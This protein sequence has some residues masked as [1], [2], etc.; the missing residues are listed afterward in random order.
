MAYSHQARQP[1]MLRSTRHSHAGSMAMPRRRGVSSGT[2]LV[3]LGI[4]GGIIPFIGPMF[5]YHMDT[6]A[7]WTFTWDRLWLSILPGAAA[8]LGGL[9]LI[10]VANRVSATVGAVLALAGGVWFV[11][12]PTFSMLWNSPLGL[13]GV[14]TG[15]TG[16]RFIEQIGFSYGLGAVV[17][18]L[19]AGAW[20]RLMVRSE[21]D[22]A[23]LAPAGGAVMTD[24]YPE[25]DVTA[26]PS[27]DDLRNDRPSTDPMAGPA[28]PAG[29]GWSAQRYDTPEGRGRQT[30]VPGVEGDETEGPRA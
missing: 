24:A 8:F 17:T 12:G 6:A 3:L 20:A 18:A 13:S 5:G 25:D 4:W 7:S 11:V 19:A 21:R 1:M 22:A 14:G 2:M 26:D 10:G 29:G 16:Q 30:D 28:G 15:S 9:I 23:L 27:M